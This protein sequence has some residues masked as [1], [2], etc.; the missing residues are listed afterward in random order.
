MKLLV[1]PVAAFALLIASHSVLGETAT[2]AMGGESCFVVR[3]KPKWCFSNEAIRTLDS[4]CSDERY[5]FR[6]KNDPRWYVEDQKEEL[7]GYLRPTRT[8][9]RWRA[10]WLLGSS[11]WVRGGLAVRTSRGY[12]VHAFGGR[13]SAWR[14]RKLGVARGRFALAIA[15]F[16]LVDGDCV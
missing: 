7:L 2:A 4:V 16:K 3:G 1:I 15:A 11:G 13:A 9:G 10:M 12:N 5:V 6:Y 8:P 14:S